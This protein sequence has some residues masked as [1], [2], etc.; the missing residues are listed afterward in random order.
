MSEFSKRS[1]ARGWQAFWLSRAGRGW[2]GRLATRIATAGGKHSRGP[3]LAA[4]APRGYIA[5]SAELIDVDLR[6]KANVFIG[7]RALLACWK[8]IV[9]GAASHAPRGEEGF[10]ELG[11]RARIDQGCD[12]EVFEGGFI[13]IGQDA[14]VQ[15]GCVLLAVLQPISIGQRSVVGPFCAFFPYDHRFVPGERMFD[16]PLDSKGPIVVGD[17]VRLG[18][19]VTVLSGVT[20]GNGAT[21]QCGSVVT[22]DI[23]AGAVAAGAPARV[24]SE[25]ESPE[26]PGSLAK[27]CV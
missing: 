15:S 17:D 6:L 9:R 23:P 24:S 4:L 1:L 5:P 8:G 10:I 2:R 14:I 18:A 19:G 12:L 21:V 26:I 20:I 13:R 25:S 22:R 27:A 3:G 16:Q 7:E 11:D